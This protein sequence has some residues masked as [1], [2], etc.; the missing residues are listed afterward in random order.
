V[1]SPH[2]PQWFTSFGDSHLVFAPKTFLLV[3]AT[4]LSLAHL[5]QNFFPAPYQA[6]KAVDELALVVLKTMHPQQSVC[7]SDINMAGDC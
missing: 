1:P 3:A 4:V 6:V 5:T 7:P 2:A